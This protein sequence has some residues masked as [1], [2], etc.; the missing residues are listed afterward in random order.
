LAFAAVAPRTIVDVR[1]HVAASLALLVPGR[2]EI[3]HEIRSLGGES[4]D[5]MRRM[6][7]Q[8]RL[9][10][11]LV[12]L[13]LGCGGGIDSAGGPVTTSVSGSVRL[14]DLSS[15]QATQICND[16]NT[17]NTATLKPTRCAK[18]RHASALLA[19]NQYLRD[20]P[21]ATDASLQ[22]ECS[23]VLTANEAYTCSD[24]VSC[25]AT[26]IASSS[27][28]CTATV[29]DI[30][31]CINENDAITR[32]LLTA[33]PD[34]ETVTMS[35]VSAYSAPGGPLDTYNVVSMSASCIRLD[36]CLGIV[37]QSTPPPGS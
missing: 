32:N 21:T 25:D 12:T 15:A 29:A 27:P 7:P 33:T 31:K 24:V 16:V 4:S 20:N 22:A 8:T 6:N 1:S 3:R 9:I 35:S 18:D 2:D 26:T 10:A 13:S 28:S 19:A 5:S 23:S 17:A 37:T 14:N 36:D 30:V 11:V 34:C